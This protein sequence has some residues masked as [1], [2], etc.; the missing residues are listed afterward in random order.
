MT[1]S[2]ISTTYSHWTKVEL[3]IETIIAAQQDLP[4][5]ELTVNVAV[6]EQEVDGYEG[7]NGETFFRSVVKTMLPDAS[8]TTLFKS[9]TEGEQRSIVN[10]WNMT[11]VLM[12]TS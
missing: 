3:T 8:G 6:M 11:Q 5:K 12:R 1:A 7:N 10:T 4:A 9:W 2:S